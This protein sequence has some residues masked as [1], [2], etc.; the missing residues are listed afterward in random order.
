MVDKGTLPHNLTETWD[1][2]V[3]AFFFKCGRQK[4]LMTTSVGPTVSDGGTARGGAEG[5]FRR[6]KLC[7][8][9][10]F[11]LIVIKHHGLVYVSCKS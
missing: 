5:R 6:S 10:N 9:W 3:W 2:A 4:L 1:F 11:E 7:N 8:R